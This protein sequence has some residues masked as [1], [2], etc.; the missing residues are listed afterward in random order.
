[1]KLVASTPGWWR[2]VLPAR[3]TKKLSMAAVTTFEDTE[4]L[5]SPWTKA[6]VLCSNPRIGPGFPVCPKTADQADPFRIIAD[7]L[8]APAYGK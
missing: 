5:A 6:E 4:T 3:E 1:M 7:N 2:I 8:S